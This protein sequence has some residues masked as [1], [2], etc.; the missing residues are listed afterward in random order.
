MLASVETQTIGVRHIILAPGITTARSE[1]TANG[2]RDYLA[3]R[4]SEAGAAMNAGAQAVDE[5]FVLWLSDDD[6]LKPGALKRLIR[7]M[8]SNPDAVMACGRTDIIA[9]N[10]V[11]IATLGRAEIAVRF[12]RWGPSTVLLPSCLFRV[13][14]L[15]EVGPFR[16]SAGVASDLDLIIRMSQVGNVVTC[17]EVTASFRWHTDSHTVQSYRDSYAVGMQVRRTHH[18]GFSRFVYEVW[19]L[20]PWFTAILGARILSWRAK[21]A[22]QEG[23]SVG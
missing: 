12:L 23:V 6:V 22:T 21:R 3:D 9:A 18:R 16:D 20:W 17:R 13:H 2:T 15:P 7:L 14:A 10:G 8:D 19:R 1:I 5:E 11:T 4:P